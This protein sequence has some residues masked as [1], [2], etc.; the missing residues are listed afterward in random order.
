M[1]ALNHPPTVLFKPHAL[2]S[3]EPVELPAGLLLGFVFASPLELP[4]GFRQR[5]NG[6]GR[7]VLLFASRLK[8]AL[9]V[10]MNRGV[11]FQHD[12]RAVRFVVLIGQNDRDGSVGWS[13]TDDPRDA[14][15]GF[16]HGGPS[17]SLDGLLGLVDEALNVAPVFLNQVPETLLLLDFLRKACQGLFLLGLPSLK[18][19]HFRGL[20]ASGT[21]LLKALLFA[22]L[23]SVSVVHALPNVD[24]LTK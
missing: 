2:A 17:V 9:G 23:K 3:L 16:A 18:F 12:L 11:E 20:A 1:P 13:S 10:L 4:F 6:T 14:L 7:L 15:D 21:C 5:L 22:S 19:L 8:I 24:S